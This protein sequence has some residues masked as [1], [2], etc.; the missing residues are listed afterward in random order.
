M[1]QVSIE[2]TSRHYTL[3]TKGTTDAVFIRGPQKDI[4]KRQATLQLAIQVKGKQIVKPTL[5][6]RN[7]NPAENRYEFPP[8][9]ASGKVK[10]EGKN[11][12]KS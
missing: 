1:D 11:S 5:I 9:L 8:G 10:F 3:E 4:E 2:M 7:A 6:M 12:E